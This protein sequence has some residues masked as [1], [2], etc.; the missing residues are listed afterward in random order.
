[1]KYEFDI[2]L[3]HEMLATMS[4]EE[5]KVYVFVE[6]TP[7]IMDFF[8]LGKP[9]EVDGRRCVSFFLEKQEAV[10]QSL[11]LTKVALLAHQGGEG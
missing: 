2:T 3:T 10:D 6:P 7:K 5:G 1:M 8:S 9:D 4:P 11:L